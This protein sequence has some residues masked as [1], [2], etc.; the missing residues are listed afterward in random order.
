MTRVKLFSEHSLPIYSCDACAAIGVDVPATE[1][2][3]MGTTMPS[4]K[5]CRPCFKTRKANQKRKRRQEYAHC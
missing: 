1:Q 2:I 4:L 5:L 3:V